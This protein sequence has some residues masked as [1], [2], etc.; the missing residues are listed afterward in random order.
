MFHNQS[1]DNVFCQ[2]PF[3]FF[4]VLGLVQTHCQSRMLYFICIKR[5]SGTNE[6][7]KGGLSISSPSSGHSC[8]ARTNVQIWNTAQICLYTIPLFFISYNLPFYEWLAAQQKTSSWTNKMT[9]FYCCKWGFRIRL[10]VH[11]RVGQNTSSSPRVQIPQL[12]RPF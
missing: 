2:T 8:C 1:I 3:I 12:E 4:N 7:W 5:E 10:M 9:F 6:G 11:T